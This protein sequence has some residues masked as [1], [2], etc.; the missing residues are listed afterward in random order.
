MKVGI[1][2]VALGLGTSI[3]IAPNATAQLNV[4]VVDLNQAIVQSEE[5]KAYLDQLRQDLEPEQEELQGLQNTILELEQKL[6]DEG[7]VMS[8]EEKRRVAKDAEDA[9]IDFEFGRQKLQKDVQD[10][11]G[12]LLRLVGPKVQA[13][14]TDLVEVERYDLVFRRE[15][16]LYV[17]ARHDI[18]A[19]VTEKL[20]ER[21]AE[22]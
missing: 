10:Q 4:A 11:Q 5:G 6:A 16:V 12:E 15:Q 14:I 19:K 7:D 9:R 13:I 21:Y 22:E 2:A 8:D 1:W 20:N 17:N 18:T 3:V